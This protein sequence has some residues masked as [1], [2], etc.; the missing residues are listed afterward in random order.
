MTG[1][2]QPR[3]QPDFWGGNKNRQNALL[4]LSI[5]LCA[6]LPI[7]LLSFYGERLVALGLT[8]Y[9]QY[10]GL[11]LIG[12]FVAAVLFAFLRLYAHYSGRHF[13]GRIELGGPAVVVAL[14][15]IAGIKLLPTS[16]NFPLTVYVHGSGGRQEL[17]LRG[18]G[19]VLV[20]TGGLRRTA[21]I[22]D[23][24]EAIFTEI[25]ANFRGQEVTIA[26]DADGYELA[27]PNKRILLNS[28]NVYVQVR[29]KPGRITGHVQDDWGNPIVG[30]GITA[31]GLSTSSDAA[32]DF[33][34]AIPGDKLQA[35]L[36]LRAA[37][38]GFEPWADTV[39]PNSNDVTITLH[40]QK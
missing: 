25:P 28:S 6:L 4:C 11:L 29:R 31:A 13:G 32:G 1:R 18:Q 12:L 33:E 36:T 20:D 8:G 37:A 39:V 40:R 22:G 5:F 2:E 9:F 30:V 26:L 15:V 7:G 24:G 10:I 21:P 34:F 16:T 17:I 35:S 23:H 38:S 3:P 27:D 14:V 19:H